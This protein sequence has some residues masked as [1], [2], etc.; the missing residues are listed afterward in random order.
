[1]GSLEECTESE[2]SDI[3]WTMENATRSDGVCQELSSGCRDDKRFRQGTR[4]IDSII[5]CII[6]CVYTR[7]QRAILFIPSH[8]AWFN[9]GSWG[10]IV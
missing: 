4:M 8:S 1:M 2:G 9:Q 10:F 5:S 6:V 7:H 3:G